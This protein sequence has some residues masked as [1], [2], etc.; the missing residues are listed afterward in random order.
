MLQR[1][2]HAPEIAQGYDYVFFDCPPRMSTACINALTCADYV[3]IPTTLSQL[4]IEAVPRT[5]NG[6]V[7][8][9]AV[10]RA[11]FLGAVITRAR[12][13][14]GKL[15]SYERKQLDT[16]NQFIR[17]HQPGDG[18]IF[19]SIIPDSP[20]IHRMT[21]EQKTAAAHDDEMRA[22]FEAVAQELERKASA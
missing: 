13:R 22:I 18:F 3:L 7:E 17:Q 20:T 4:D 15:V 14:A 9:H 12:L 19:S 1:I 6:L 5:L 11:D 16:L 10:V 2:L 8:L 21:A